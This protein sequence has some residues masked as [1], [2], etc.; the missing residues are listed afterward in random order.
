VTASMI[1]YAC[2]DCVLVK[3][4]KKAETPVIAGDLGI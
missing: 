4:N 3:K 1:V 2:D